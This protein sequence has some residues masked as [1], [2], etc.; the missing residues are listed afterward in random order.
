MRPDSPLTPQPEPASDSRPSTHRATAPGSPRPPAHAKSASEDRSCRPPHA[1]LAFVSANDEPLRLIPKLLAVFF[2]LEHQSR[3]RTRTPEALAYFH[4]VERILRHPR[5][6]V[7]SG[8]KR[9]PIINREFNWRSHGRNIHRNKNRIGKI[10][11]CGG[12]EGVTLTGD[13]RPISAWKP[14]IWYFT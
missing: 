6:M 10:P 1:P 12:T 4:D 13:R 3:I 11:F 14:A 2:L 5:T 9:H 7:R 8:P